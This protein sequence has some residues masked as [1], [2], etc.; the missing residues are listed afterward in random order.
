MININESVFEINEL[1]IKI[2]M[3]MVQINKFN[4]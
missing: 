3:S 1:M 2:D 4:D